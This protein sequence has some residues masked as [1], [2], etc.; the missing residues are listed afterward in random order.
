MATSETAITEIGTKVRINWPMWFDMASN[1]LQNVT[2]V[3]ATKEA[4]YQRSRS[5]LDNINFAHLFERMNPDHTFVKALES[6]E[7]TA[8]KL[9]SKMQD[10]IRDRDEN[11]GF[12]FSKDKS[13]PFCLVLV[14]HPFAMRRIISIFPRFSLREID[15]VVCCEY[16]CHKWFSAVQSVL[17]IMTK[18]SLFPSSEEWM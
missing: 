12:I 17:H 16:S 7:E 5:Q 18:V 13:A 4:N 6:L 14:K 10:Q 1:I 15:R 9:Q 3:L 8:K 11:S 2:H